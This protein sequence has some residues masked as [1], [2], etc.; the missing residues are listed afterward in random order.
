MVHCSFGFDDREGVPRLQRRE[1]AGGALLDIGVYA[2]QAASLAFGQRDPRKVSACGHLTEA[3]VDR[4][5]AMT[6]DYGDG[7]LAVLSCAIHAHLPNECVITGSKGTATLHAPFWCSTRVSVKWH[8]DDAAAAAAAAPAAVPA[9]TGTDYAIPP[10]PP[11]RTFN[12]MNSQG[13]LYEARAVMGA[14]RDGRTQLDEISGDE[15][16]R[17]MGILDEARKQVGVVYPEEE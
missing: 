7:K 15:T 9:A 11:G 5:V 1:L 16:M 3:G 14:V 12:F 10:V 6:L 8:D 13:F 17:I 2:V 4:D